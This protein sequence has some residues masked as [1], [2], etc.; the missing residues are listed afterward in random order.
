MLDVGGSRT[1]NHEYNRELIDE[2]Y[3]DDE[4][5]HEPVGYVLVEDIPDDAEDFTLQ[6]D[7]ISNGMEVNDLGQ[8]KLQKRNIISKIE[9]Y[10]KKCFLAACEFEMTMRY[11]TMEELKVV[12]NLNDLQNVYEVWEHQL[13][14]F[15]D[16][17]G[18]FADFPIIL[19]AV[20][21]VI[22]FYN[23]VHDGIKAGTRK[24]PQVAEA[25]RNFKPKSKPVVVAL[26]TRIRFVTNG[27]RHGDCAL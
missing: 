25:I 10:N 8:A 24:S 26:V 16:I 5:P 21:D 12:Y 2:E 7:N 9:Q 20:G 27:L 22:K 14:K 4:C 18:E 19:K 1:P 17:V 13:K 23:E 11:K 3:P 15:T 6:F